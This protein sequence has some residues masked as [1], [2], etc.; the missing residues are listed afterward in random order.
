MN[1][2]IGIINNVIA[3][4][5]INLVIFSSSVKSQWEMPM[6]SIYANTFA[7]IGNITLSAKQSVI[8]STNYGISWNFG[9]T[10]LPNTNADYAKCLFVKGSKVFL[11]VDI[12]GTPDGTAGLYS[13]RD[14][15]KTWLPSV[16]GFYNGASIYTL[17]QKDSLLIA[18]TGS[19][20]YFS[21]NDGSS[22]YK[23]STQLNNKVIS[24]LATNGNMVFTGILGASVQDPLGVYATSNNGVNW[25]MVN[26]G[27]PPLTTIYS[28]V[29]LNGTLFGTSTDGRIFKTTNNGGNWTLSDSGMTHFYNPVYAIAKFR[30]NLL[31]GCDDGIFLSTNAGKYWTLQNSGI[32]P[33]SHIQK[34]SIIQSGNY[35]FIPANTGIYRR[36]INQVS[37]QNIS[38][39]IS[40]D[41]K[42]SQNYPNP[43]NPA[44]KIRF[45]L[46]KASFVT[47]KVYNALGREVRVLVSEKLNSGV[48][49]K[50]FNAAD[51]TSGVY[52]YKIMTDDFVQ[53]RKM[54]LLK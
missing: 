2:N 8:S 29:F 44:T 9:A 28:M 15:G 30:N 40:N 22:W 5:I 20:V 21:S 19:G 54:L 46:P 52:F 6:D 34:N 16:T 18:G 47:L 10:G 4:L 14:S 26:N 45:E 25:T 39:S 3:L 23:P 33:G 36:D 38:S 11:G 24:C 51:L 27:L 41:F 35:V 50:N 49:E 37:I 17:A 48:Y 31:V 12:N 1:R 42:L 13:S 53:T 7:A 43:F 32:I